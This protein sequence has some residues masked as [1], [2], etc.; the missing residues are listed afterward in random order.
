VLAYRLLDEIT[1]F[2]QRDV[3]RACLKLLFK[4]GQ[5]IAQISLYQPSSYPGIAN[6]QKGNC[7]ARNSRLWQKKMGAFFAPVAANEV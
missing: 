1:A 2:V 4:K 5:R 7:C 3:A 6:S